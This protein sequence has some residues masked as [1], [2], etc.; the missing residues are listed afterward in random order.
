MIFKSFPEFLPFIFG[1][2]IPLVPLEKA[3]T[4]SPVYCLCLP[5]A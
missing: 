5:R 1:N 2:I 3:G 4:M